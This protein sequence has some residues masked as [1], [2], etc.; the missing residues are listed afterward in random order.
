MTRSLRITAMVLV[1]LAGPAGAFTFTVDSTGD[2]ADANTADDTCIATGGGCTLRAAIEQAN[3]SAGGLDTIKFGIT[4]GGVHTIK[5]AT[6]LPQINDPVLIDGYQQ[7]GASQNTLSAGDNAM[8][9][10]E[11]D[12]SMCV[13]CTALDIESG[14]SGSTI[15]GLAV[16]RFD[17]G[18][19]L[20]SATTCTIEGNFIGTDPTGTIARANAN[21]GIRLDTAVGNL[22]GG[23]TPAARNVIS[24]NDSAG[25]L[26]HNAGIT[27]SFGSDVNTIQGNFI[28]VDSTGAVALQNVHGVASFGAAHTLIGG[29]TAP[30]RNVI[31]GNGGAGIFL[32]SADENMVRGNF[33]GTDVTGTKAVGNAQGGVVVAGSAGNMIGG[34]AIGAGNVISANGFEGV[35]LLLG[36]TGSIVE[37]NRIGTDVTGTMLLGNPLRGVFIADASD[38]RIGG[39][40]PGAGNLIA[41][42]G[43][44]GVLLRTNT[45]DPIGNQILGNSI[46][47]NGDLGIALDNDGPDTNDAGD[48]DAGQNNHQNYPVLDTPM[49]AGGSSV[50]GTLGSTPGRTYRIEVFGNT[51]CDPSLYGE[52][53]TFL[54]AVTTGMTDGSGHVAFVVDFGQTIGATALTA[55]AT[56]L[57]TNDTSEFSACLAPPTTTTTS[58]TAT[59][60]T[61]SIGATTTSTTTP[62]TT[63]STSTTTLTT[64]TSTAAPTTVTTSTS[65]LSSTS[66][67]T[68]TTSTTAALVTTTTLATGCDAV[69]DGPTF[70]SILCRVAALRATTAATAELGELRGKLDQPLGKAL[71]RI[72]TA[73]DSCASA[74]KKHAKAR[75]KQ[76]LP[77]LSKYSHR[78]R[79][80]KARKTAP[81]EIREPL[82]AEA[83]AIVGAATTLRTGLR[84]PADAS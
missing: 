65:I 14:G 34:A 75:L 63:S 32:S 74:D 78:L 6:A 68:S 76:V 49:F 30:E 64:S 29:T 19:F 27:V 37:G 2:T 13:G 84:C 23:S 72:G 82:A 55:T 4:G 28:G 5:P 77:Q 83:D 8:I 53:K 41:G 35:G 60:T 67:S 3:V 7:P 25:T 54:G 11:L 59:T 57:T 21:E 18:I 71:D 33:L 17:T 12:G 44:Y 52:G 20:N 61:T 43:T 66:S 1:L 42:N 45:T 15:R 46:F 56:D 40:D 36:A 10:I 26:Q 9:L 48:G 31:S 69:P 81:A 79:G 38:N 73:K 47:A 22:I 24:G 16:G 62:S 80:A 58:T 51:E 70:A 39:T 50:S